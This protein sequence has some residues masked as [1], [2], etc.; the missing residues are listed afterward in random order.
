MA[1]NLRQW[2]E[3]DLSPPESAPEARPV[4]VSTRRFDQIRSQIHREMLT[5]LDLRKFEG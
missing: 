4:A 5:E 1:L 3:R 2:L